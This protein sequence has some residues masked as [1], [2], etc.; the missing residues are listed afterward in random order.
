MDAFGVDREVSKALFAP[1][2][3]MGMALKP[4]LPKKQSGLNTRLSLRKAQA[5]DKTA[6]VMAQR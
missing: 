4:F 5:R 1:K 2:K 6:Q 3:D